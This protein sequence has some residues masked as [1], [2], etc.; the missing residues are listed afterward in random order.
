L[1][2]G[3]AYV[4][5]VR[6][7]AVD[8]RKTY[9]DA[10]KPPARYAAWIMKP[11][12]D[13]QIVDLGDA[14]PIERAVAGAR[15]TLKQAPTEVRDVGEPQ[16]AAE[17]HKALADLARRVLQPLQAH[18]DDAERWI[19][20]P[21]GN[22]WLVPWA[23]L[24]IDGSTFAIEKHTIHLV[25]SGRDLILDPLKLDLKAREPLVVADPDFDLA[26]VGIQ[27]RPLVA[28]DPANPRLRAA[29]LQLDR[30]SRLPH[31]AIEGELVADRL[32]KWLGSRPR[33]LFDKEALAGTVR[34]TKA[35]RVLVLA[36][37]GFFLPEPEAPA[38]HSI[39][40]KL[41]NPLMRCGLLLAGSNNART[42]RAD[43]D[44]GVLTGLDVVGLDLR[45][46]ELVVLSA[47]E[48]GLGV[49]NNGEGVAGLRQ[50]F[51]LAGAE[52][53]MA[54]LWAVPDRDTA[55]LMVRVF[56]ELAAG[57][58]RAEALQSAQRAQIARRRKVFGAA[59][60]F[61]WAAFTITGPGR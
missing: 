46:T 26:P 3:S 20:C 16:A 11:G 36:T 24:P 31:T 42:A 52:S 21:D 8:F 2:A 41:E 57:K 49:V 59:H 61:F 4:D 56:D 33:T 9:N 15:R 7:H 13:V 19:F 10:A 38:G 53:V 51:Q 17:A 40:P 35:P 58:G 14:E 37:H 5:F 47:C 29:G 54:S 30:V 50:A 32:A 23:A 25:I 34:A 22:L 55:M 39:K 44:N 60:P 6:Y 28:P 45:G 48:T 27:R 12:S 43:Q 18:I 1:P